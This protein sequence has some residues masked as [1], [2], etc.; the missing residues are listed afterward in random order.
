MCIASS[1]SLSRNSV[2]RKTELPAAERVVVGSTGNAACRHV[3][4]RGAAEQAKG[5]IGC[6]NSAVTT[7]VVGRNGREKK[8]KSRLTPRIEVGTARGEMARWLVKCSFG[9]KHS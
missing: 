2:G 9:A 3:F 1:C 7:Q 8:R 5:R 4:A 6:Q